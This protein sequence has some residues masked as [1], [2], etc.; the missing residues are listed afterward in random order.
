MSG[1]SWPTWEVALYGFSEVYVEAPSKASA[2]WW[3]ASRCHEAGYG[4]SP[5]ELIQRGVDVRE[6]G[7]TLA[8][9]MSGDSPIYRVD[10]RRVA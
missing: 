1:A 9:I 7:H 4:R 3:A 6:V 5:V 2:R 8:A 10:P